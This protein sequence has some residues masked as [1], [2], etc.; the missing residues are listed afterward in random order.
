MSSRR[1]VV[2][3]LE[4][5]VEMMPTRERVNE[6]A[7]SFELGELVR[8][9]GH[10]RGRIAALVAEPGTVLRREQL[11]EQ[12]WDINWFGSTKTLDMHISVLRRKLGDDAT[13]RVPEQVEPL[14]AEL[15]EAGVEV[16][17]ELVERVGGRVAGVGGV[18]VAAVLLSIFVWWELRTRAPMLPATIF[19]N[20]RFSAASVSITSAFFALFGFGF[21]LTQHFHLLPRDGPL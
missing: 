1:G 12:V 15:V 13:H 5:G 6:P 20:L 21:L 7:T 10:Q 2:S 16:V 19:R 11:L 17:G 4:F 8:E 14:D 9:V 3:C 18:G